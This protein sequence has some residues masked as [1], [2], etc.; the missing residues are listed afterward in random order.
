[1]QPQS[2]GWRRRT[3]VGAEGGG[4]STKG[5]ATSGTPRAV[6]AAGRGAAGGGRGGSVAA[7]G[8]GRSATARS[9]GNAAS[10][11]G[12]ATGRGAWAAVQKQ[13]RCCF[14]PRLDLFNGAAPPAPASQ[15]RT[16]SV[17][18]FPCPSGWCGKRKQFRSPSL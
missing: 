14:E 13:F 7:K 15:R 1:M 10:A 4:G 6:S 5:R 12:A 17:L 18:L 9:Q 3:A 11:P 16:E 2:R 8:P